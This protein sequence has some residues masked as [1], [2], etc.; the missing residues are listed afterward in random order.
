[1]GGR[2]LRSGRAAA[3]ALCTAPAAGLDLCS[4]PPASLPPRQILVNPADPSSHIY[5]ASATG[6]AARFKGLTAED[7]LVGWG[8]LGELACGRGRCLEAPPRIHTPEPPCR[9]T[10]ASR[11]RE[12]WVRRWRG[13]VGWPRGLAAGGGGGIMI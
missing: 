10:S 1:M 3:Y 11:A 13:G 7:M 9:C 2:G 4:A 8:G 6:D 12:T 5:K